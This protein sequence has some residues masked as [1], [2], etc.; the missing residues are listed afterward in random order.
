M[1]G[2][3]KVWIDRSGRLLRLRLDRPKANILDAALV[4]ALEGAFVQQGGAAELRGVLIDASGAHFSF[5]A[6]IEEHLPE[7]CAA[8]L[9]GFHRLVLRLF[10]SPVPV[11]VAVRGQCLGGGL[12]LA[13]AGHLLFAAPDAKFGQPEIQ[14]GVFAPAASCLLP[15]RI[16]LAAAEDLLLSGRSIGADDACAM[17]LVTEIAD[18]PEAAALGYFDRYL[19]PKSASSLRFATR[20][21]RRG[22]IEKVSAK[23]AA[24]E[25]MYLQELMATQDAVEGLSAFIEKRPARW[26]DL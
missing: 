10:A 9:A 7:R 19:A 8:M 16:G 14:I 21:V 11:L 17:G 15:E 25:T 5:G 4:G 3:L 24:I 12:E 26:K 2:P 22:T 23:L 1:S 20:A 18:D 6:S 13:S